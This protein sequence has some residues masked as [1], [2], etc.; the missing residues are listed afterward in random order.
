[1]FCLLVC[2]GVD[3]CCCFGFGIAALQ[4]YLLWW[5]APKS[6]FHF[7]T[8]LGEHSGVRAEWG[9]PW[10]SQVCA[11]SLTP[12]TAVTCSCGVHKQILKR[13]LWHVHDEDHRDFICF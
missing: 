5:F 11:A 2:F 6:P 4:N 9:F 12:G 1:M 7:R 13:L 3:F 10:C 8:C